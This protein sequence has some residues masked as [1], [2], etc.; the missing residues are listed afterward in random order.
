MH[1]DEAQEE[2]GAKVLES[3]D[4][5]EVQHHNKPPPIPTLNST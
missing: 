3:L 2:M 4:Y 5:L 1:W